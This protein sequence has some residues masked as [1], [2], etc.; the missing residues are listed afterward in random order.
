MKTLKTISTFF[1]ILAIIAI[2]DGFTARLFETLG[3]TFLNG[4]GINIFEL[5]GFIAVWNWLNR[6]A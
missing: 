5:I 4:K 3:W 6:E 1:V 2:L